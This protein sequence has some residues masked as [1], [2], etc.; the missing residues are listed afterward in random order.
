MQTLS[1]SE[2][3]PLVF[4]IFSAQG[5]GRGSPRRQEGREAV[6]SFIESPR[7]GGG[8]PQG[9][10]KFSFALSPLSVGFPRGKTF[11]LNIG[12]N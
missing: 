12:R 8:S 10:R 5:S 3:I 9:A 7:R 6:G 1:K 2:K 11:K 4:F